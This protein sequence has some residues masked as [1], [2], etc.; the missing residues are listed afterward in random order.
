M[1]VEIGSAMSEYR[2]R[3][4]RFFQFCDIFVGKLDGDG[5]EGFIELVQLGCTD[6]R[7][8]HTLVQQP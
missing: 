5:R 4:V 2:M 8:G 6:D 1:W 7:S 3:L